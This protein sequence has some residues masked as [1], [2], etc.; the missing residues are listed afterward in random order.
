MPISE[1]RNGVSPELERH[2]G[3]EG[4]PWN[5]DPLDASPSIDLENNSEWL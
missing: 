5:Q 1:R 4:H 2:D 3:W